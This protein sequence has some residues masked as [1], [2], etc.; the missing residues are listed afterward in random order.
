MNN[1]HS[2]KESRKGV[3]ACYG[4]VLPGIYSALLPNQLNQ[5]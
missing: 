4:G 2:N 5:H 3:D 1:D